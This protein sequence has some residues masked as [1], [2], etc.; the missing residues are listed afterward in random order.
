MD[1]TY[2][3]TNLRSQISR[4]GYDHIS[5]EAFTKVSEQDHNVLP[6]SIDQLDKHSADLAKRF[7]SK[8]VERI[9]NQNGNVEEAKFVN[10]VHN[11]YEACDSRGTPMY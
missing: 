6:K 4:H 9:L 3:L 10:L 1:P 8:D 7:F 2:I 5:T 11:W